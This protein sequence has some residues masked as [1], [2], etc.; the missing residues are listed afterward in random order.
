MH[1]NHIFRHFHHSN[2]PN[3]KL[4]LHFDFLL[5]FIFL[6]RCELCFLLATNFQI[7]ACASVLFIMVSVISFCLKT[8]PGFRVQM[9][10]SAYG[11]EFLNISV[12]QYGRSPY[13]K[14]IYLNK[15]LKS[16]MPLHKEAFS[17]RVNGIRKQVPVHQCSGFLFYKYS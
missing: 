14:L 10:P 3:I 13:C 4:N 15:Y 17:I 9:S 7:V 2:V 5:S 12:N 16:V 8:H 6:H 1:Q 11:G